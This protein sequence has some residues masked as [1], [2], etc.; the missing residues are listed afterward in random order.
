[1]KKE[2]IK[3]IVVAFVLTIILSTISL[4][5]YF[6]KTKINVNSGVAI[7]IIKLEG[8]QKLI[9]NNN[10]ENKVYNLAV[11]NYDE[12]E[13]ITQVELEYYIEII[14]KKNDD[15]N[16][17]IYKE[18]KELNINNCNSLIVDFSMV[19]FMDSSAIGMLIGRY[20][21]ITLLGGKI[22]VCGIKGNLER[23]YTLSGLYKIIEN[24]DTVEKA[25]EYINGGCTY[26]QSK[27]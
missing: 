25:I 27:N 13:Q 6:N 12:N 22:A 11:K 9:I 7:P 23:I 17:K 26:E 20:K 5:K 24:K 10:Q 16:F 14:S 18:E 4:G 1:M 8:E 3:I 19:D 2:I 15:I 21:D